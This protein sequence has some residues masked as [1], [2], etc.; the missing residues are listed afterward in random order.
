MATEDKPPRDRKARQWQIHQL[1]VLTHACRSLGIG[2]VLYT[3]SEIGSMYRALCKIETERL[4][5]LPE[6]IEGK[7]AY[8][9]SRRLAS[10]QNRNK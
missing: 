4:K 2:G 10:A 6:M 9:K 1:T 7:S 5:S 8:L 3:D